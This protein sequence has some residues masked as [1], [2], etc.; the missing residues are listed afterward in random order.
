[1]GVQIRIRIA[2]VVVV[3]HRVD[4]APGGDLRLPD[5]PGAGERRMLLQEG[6][7]GVAGLLVG[8]LDGVADPLPLV[9]RPQQDKGFDRG[10]DQVVAR[11]AAPRAPGFFGPDPADLRLRRAA[12]GLLLDDGEPVGDPGVEVLQ[13][14]V[15]RE[16]AAERGG[17]HCLLGEL[18]ELLVVHAGP[19]VPAQVGLDDAVGVRVHPGTEQVPHLGFGHLASQVEGG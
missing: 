5:I 3:E 2:R 16:P 18:G 9:E 4:Q 8:L 6:E 12:A 10:E 13:G 1:V 17:A 7:G 14:R 11:D 19:G 15:H